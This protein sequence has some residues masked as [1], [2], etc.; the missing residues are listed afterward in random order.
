MGQAE[1]SLLNRPPAQGLETED[2]AEEMTIEE[3][4]QLGSAIRKL[5]GNKLKKFNLKLPEKLKKIVTVMHAREAL[6]RGSSPDNV[7][8]DYSTFQRDLRELERFA[9]PY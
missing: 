1:T 4:Q 5:S 3:M 2:D 8:I 9:A 6:L 7:E